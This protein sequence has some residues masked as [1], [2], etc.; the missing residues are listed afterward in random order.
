MGRAH[1]FNCGLLHSFRFRVLNVSIFLCSFVFWDF[2]LWIFLVNPVVGSA[3]AAVGFSSR[4][5]LLQSRSSL[6]LSFHATVAGK[7]HEN[8]IV[9]VVAI[10]VRG[11]VEF[12]N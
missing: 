7:V 11:F 8:C 1:K 6:P 12:I 4:R 9:V 2:F 3:L 5:C 10:V